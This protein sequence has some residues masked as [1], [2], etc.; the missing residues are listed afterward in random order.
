MINYLSKFINNLSD[1]IVPVLNMIRKNTEFVWKIKK[2]LTSPSVYI[3]TLM[4]S[5]V[6]S[7]IEQKQTTI[8]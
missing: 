4:S 8:K 1:L 7:K 5:R 2:V 3:T 6:L